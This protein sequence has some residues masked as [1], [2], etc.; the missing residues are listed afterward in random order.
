MTELVVIRHGET[1]LNRVGSFQG[2]IDVELNEYGLNQAEQL[3]RRMADEHFDAVYT[4]DLIRTRQ[5]AQPLAT[6]LSLPINP[7]LGLREQHFGELEGKPL[8]WVKE[9]HPELWETWL[10]F[11]ADFAVPGGES[12]R[13]FSARVLATVFGLAQKHQGERLLVVAHGGVLDMLYRHA[14]GFSLDGP[15]VCAIPNTGVNRLVV[16]QEIIRIQVWGDD[17]HL[18]D[19]AGPV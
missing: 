7:V 2:Q 9:Q 4:S 14:K 15:R 16:E 19:Q 17:T 11:R 12:V 10:L 18:R 1:N 13:R 5:T 8:S 3:A 6:R